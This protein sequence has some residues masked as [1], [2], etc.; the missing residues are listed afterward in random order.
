MRAWSCPWG[1]MAY[2]HLLFGSVYF[3]LCFSFLK[4]TRGSHLTATRFCCACHNDD[5]VCSSKKVAG[6]DPGPG[7]VFWVVMVS[8]CLYR[9]SLGSP[10]SSHSPITCTWGELENPGVSVMASACQCVTPSLPKRLEIDS[11]IPQGPSVRVKQSRKKER[12]TEKTWKSDSGHYFM[13]VMRDSGSSHKHAK[14]TFKDLTKRRRRQTEAVD[15]KNIN[16]RRS[17]PHLLK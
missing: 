9:F 14:H 13:R 11:R 2:L 6:F 17:R 12:I 15:G 8:F 4:N 3:L 10:A 7:A 16:G 5:K 1:L